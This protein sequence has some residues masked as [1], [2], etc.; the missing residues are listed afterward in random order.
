M[1]NKFTSNIFNRITLY[2]QLVK[3]EPNYRIKGKIKII[4]NGS[5]KIGDSFRANSGV[6]FNPI[7][8]DIVLRLISK[9]DSVLIIGNNVG[10][11]NSTIFCS[12][13]ILI[14]NNVL[15]GGGCK[16][17]DTDFHS[18]DVET[19]NSDDD[20]F[21]AAKKE[22]I[23]NDNVFIGSNSIILKGVTI[24]KNSIIAAGSIVSKNIPAN[25]IWGGNPC[26]FIRNL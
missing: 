16:F 17:W 12:K 24:G 20:Y 4:N 14:G 9:K 1:I 2:E 23:I 11:S 25:E 21:K 22:I 8:G 26:K 19:R 7:G 6:N 3:I 10:I 13:K 18:L 15:I 5:I